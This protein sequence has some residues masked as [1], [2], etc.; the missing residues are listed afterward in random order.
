MNPCPKPRRGCNSGK[1]RHISNPTPTI[2]D[3]CEDCGAPH[4]QLHEV[5]AGI[6]RRNLSIKYG[7]QRRLCDRCHRFITSA[8]GGGRDAELKRSYQARFEETHTREEFI[9]LFGRNYL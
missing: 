6:G 7:L 9:R 2:D 3:L 4:A 8:A 1:H 5:Y